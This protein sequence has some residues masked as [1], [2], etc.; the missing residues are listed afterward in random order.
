MHGWQCGCHAVQ[1]DSML[2]AWPVC[3]QCVT[4]VLGCGVEWI[5]DGVC[6][7]AELP[8]MGLT[9]LRAIPLKPLCSQQQDMG[10]LFHITCYTWNVMKVMNGRWKWTVLRADETW[11]ILQTGGIDLIIHLSGYSN[12]MPLSFICLTVGVCDLSYCSSVSW[13]WLSVIW[14]MVKWSGWLITV[15][16]TERQF[17]P[18]KPNGTDPS[19]WATFFQ[20]LLSVCLELTSQMCI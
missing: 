13:R 16:T 3:E 18:S 5:Y 19:P 6:S 14:W 12:S 17:L 2:C 20:T 4:S 7:R 11:M 10:A 9:G 8:Q 15:E 1:Y